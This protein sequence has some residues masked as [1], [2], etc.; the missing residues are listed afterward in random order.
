MY[1]KIFTSLFDGSM[2]GKPDLI[3]V[4]VNLLCHS[5]EEGIV[6]RHYKAVADETGLSV[7]RVLKALSEL[8]SPDPESRTPTNEGRRIT[9]LDQNRNWG[10]LITNHKH[11]RE[12]IN[13]QDRRKYMRDYMENWRKERL[14]ARVNNGKQNVNTVSVSVNGDVSDKEG[15]SKGGKTK[16][17]GEFQNVLLTDKEYAKLLAEQGQD[18]LN[19]GIE[20]L[21]DY[22]KSKG[23]R[24]KCHYAVLKKTG[25][26][27]SKIGSNDRRDNVIPPPDYEHPLEL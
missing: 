24:Y 12:M 23:K 26:V 6:D 9:R 27:W 2:R 20:I 15:D 14:L 7:E 3:L 25:W 1:A 5:D 4:F 8:E 17:Y 22:M 16:P 13:A 11:Y 21:G 18:R 10:W 19:E